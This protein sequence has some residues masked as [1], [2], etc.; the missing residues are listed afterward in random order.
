VPKTETMRFI[1]TSKVLGLGWRAG[2]ARQTLSL[3]L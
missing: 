2:L 3:T 1:R